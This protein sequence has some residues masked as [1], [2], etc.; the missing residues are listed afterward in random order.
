[1]SIK[2]EFYHSRF[3]SHWVRTAAPCFR[4]SC[5]WDFRNVT[6]ATRDGRTRH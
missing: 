6:I 3:E 5:S 2:T 4:C 1:M